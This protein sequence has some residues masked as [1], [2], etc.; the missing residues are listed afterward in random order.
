MTSRSLATDG[1]LTDTQALQVIVRN[2]AGNTIAGTSKNNKVDATHAI[3]SQAATGEEDYIDGKKGN[4]KL[5]GLAGND[6][7][8]GGAGKDTLTGGAGFDRLDGGADADRFVFSAKLGDAGVDTIVKFE[9]NKDLL[10]LDDKP[11]KAIGNSLSSSEFYAKAGATKAHDGNDRIVYDKSSGKLY[12][13]DDGKGGHNAVHFATLTNK[14][15][16]DAGDF[17]HRL[18]R[19]GLAKD[20]RMAS[21]AQIFA[22]EG[23]LAFFMTL[24][25]A[26]AK[27]RSFDANPSDGVNTIEVVKNDVNG[28]AAPFQIDAFKDV[29]GR[30]TLLETADM[31][32]LAPVATGNKNYP[33][34]GL[35]SGLFT[36]KNGAALLARSDDALFIAFRG[37]NDISGDFDIGNTPDSKQWGDKRPDHYKLF[38]KLDAAVQLYLSQHPEVTKVYVTGH[39][40]G[41]GMVNAFMQDHKS[42]IYEA[43]SFGSIRYGKG[44]GTDSRVTNVWNDS[45]IALAIGGRADGASIKFKVFGPDAVSEHMPWLYSAEIKFLEKQGYDIA[46]LTG[47]SRIVFGATTTGVFDYGIGISAD[48]LSGT[49]GRDLM[50]GGNETDSLQGLAGRDRIDGGSGGRDS[51]VYKE[52]TAGVS[53]TLD[54]DHFVT[55]TVGGK[56][57]DRIVNIE[58]VTG[59]SGADRLTG[60]NRSNKLIG[61]GGADRLAGNGAADTLSGGAGHDTLSGGEGN[62]AFVFNARVSAGNADRIADFTWGEDSLYLEYDVFKKLGQTLT[63]TEFYAAAGAVKA[64][65]KSDRIIYNT[66]TGKLYYDD[67]GKGSHAPVLVATLVDKP[68]LT[69]DDF[70]IV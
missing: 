42:S 64:H 13:D 48:E 62:D 39:S 55:V 43:V 65:D 34:K 70:N 4:D 66:D 35:E 49:S 1:V 10:G 52:K 25:S 3:N 44:S 63:G 26:A 50:F 21:A 57:E 41:G 20:V 23:K 68:L 47:W 30:L 24:S 38:A 32:S 58:D 56:S 11:F 19:L 53:V 54:G 9:H 59:G 5:N 40:L 27:L 16:L 31:P 33:A 69:V 6:T 51:A 15:M 37:S 61:N 7:L 8:I 18:G 17:F 2:V 12:Y 36:N 67:D 28:P 45:D 29:Q 46:D 14:P 60:D 22:D